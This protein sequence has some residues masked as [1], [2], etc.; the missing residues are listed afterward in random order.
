MSN[1][2]EIEAEDKSSAN[3]PESNH[4]H[5]ATLNLSATIKELQNEIATLTKE[6]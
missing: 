6:T 5:P 4:C 3:Q 2:M 1:D